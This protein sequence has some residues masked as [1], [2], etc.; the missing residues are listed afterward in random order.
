MYTEEEKN[1]VLNLNK[2]GWGVSDIVAR[3]EMSRAT[4]YRILKETEENETAPYKEE[5]DEMSQNSSLLHYDTPPEAYNE[6][7]QVSD[8]DEEGGYDYDPLSQSSTSA[9]SQNRLNSENDTQYE[10]PKTQPPSYHQDTHAYL[11]PKVEML[12]L[13]LVHEREMEK[14][15]Q[16]ARAL[17]LEE[18]KLR[19]EAS[20]L[21][22]QEK[23]LQQQDRDYQKKLLEEADKQRHTSKKLLAKIKQA[24]QKLHQEGRRA[25]YSVADLEE[26]RKTF[27]HLQKQVEKVAGEQNEDAEAWL[28]DHM[29]GRML[30]TI[31][32]TT[33]RIAR[34][35]FSNSLSLRWEEEDELLLERT[36]NAVILN[37]P[38]EDNADDVN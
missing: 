19:N 37:Q 25:E 18:T 2:E 28:V 31:E 24:V 35:L 38:L 13:R 5:V 11:N 3:T 15:R 6:E 34:N 7:E 8:E 26:L 21:Q 9:P 4:V 23:Q 32:A 33:E 10:T 16:Q 22:F 14:L 30:T 27:T 36:V 20:Q 17:E 29:L 12:R 1:E